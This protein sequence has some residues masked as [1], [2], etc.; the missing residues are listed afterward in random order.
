MSTIPIFEVE[1]A[2]FRNEELETGW[3]NVRINVPPTGNSVRWPFL[4]YP[5]S[6]PDFQSFTREIPVSDRATPRRH[7]V[8]LYDA[9]LHE[10]HVYPLDRACRVGLSPIQIARFNWG[11]LRLLYANPLGDGTEIMMFLNDDDTGTCYLGDVVY[12]TVELHQLISKYSERQID[13]HSE[14]DLYTY[15]DIRDKHLGKNSSQIFTESLIWEDVCNTFRLRP[16]GNYKPMDVVEAHWVTPDILSVT[17]NRETLF[18]GNIWDLSDKPETLVKLL[19]KLGV[20]VV[21]SP[22]EE[23]TPYTYSAEL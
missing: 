9:P 16:S 5:P 12:T 14:R 15:L 11:V 19:T 17:K 6:G 2:P 13:P 8:R 7:R 3:G 23:A 4:S 10:N 18:Q 22:S 21:N 1:H 20:N